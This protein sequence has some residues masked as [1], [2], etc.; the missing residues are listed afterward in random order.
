MLA[1]LAVSRTPGSQ[2][3]AHGMMRFVA[4]D[5]FGNRGSLRNVAL[6]YFYYL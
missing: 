5:C 4:F 6:L 2:Y 1:P 3:R